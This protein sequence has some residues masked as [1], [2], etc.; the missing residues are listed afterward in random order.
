[1]AKTSFEWDD[2][3]D[4]Q[5]QESHGV[6]FSL[7]QF[8]FTDPNRVIAQDLNHSDEENRYFCFGKVEDGILTVRFTY[9]SKRIRIFGAGYWRRGKKIYEQENNLH[10]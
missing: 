10:K 8:A 3:K 6:P 4:L 1:M 5:N 7:A 2:A 9:R